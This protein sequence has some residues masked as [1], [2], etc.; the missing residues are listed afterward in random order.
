MYR[1]LVS[2]TARLF[3]PSVLVAIAALMAVTCLVTVRAPVVAQASIL[4]DEGDEVDRFVKENVA[5]GVP[6]GAPVTATGNGKLTYGLSGADSAYFTINAITGQLLLAAGAVLDFESGKTVY[7]LVVTAMGQTDQ[8]ASVNVTVNVEDVNEPPE[9]DVS[10][11]SLEVKENSPAGTNVGDPIEAADP[12]GDDVTYSLAGADANSFAIDAANGQVKIR[13]PLNFE[14]RN[15]YKVKVVASDLYGSGSSAGIDLTISVTDI[16]TEAPGKPGKPSVSPDP[17]QGHEALLVEWTAPENAGP[18]I[19]GYVVQYRVEGSGEKWKPVKVDTGEGEETITGLKSDAVY[20]VQ[21]RAVNDEGEGQWSE[22][23]K[24]RT[25]AAQTENSPPNF[26]ANAATALTVAEN[27]PPGTAVGTPFTASDA[28]PKDTLVYSLADADS[29]LFAIDDASGQISIGQRTVLDFE[30]PA[31]SD[32]NNVYELTVRVTDGKDESG[33]PNSEIDDSID[34]TVRVT[35]VNEP[36]DV[37]SLGSELE[38]DENSPGPLS[39][40]S[41]NDPEGHTVTWSLDA[42]SP[43]A[44]RFSLS[45][46]GTIAFKSTPDFETPLDNDRDNDY[47]IT[48]IATDDGLPSASSRMALSIRVVE[49]RRAGNGCVVHAGPAG[50]CSTEGRTL[51]HGWRCG[52]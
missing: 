40:L 2:A 47:E 36:P 35:N 1:P 15:S 33:N 21:V 42:A 9:F 32:G 17:A 11:V 38:A 52:R 19:T 16:D 14:A 12:E 28:D 37:S 25:Y 34:V 10:D 48:V 23:G 7:R 41:V 13:Q 39:P 49:R 8:T 30:S 4:F 18:P 27:T 3:T 31:D 45:R 22:S 29:G 20:E 43:D 26:A 6:V 5:A 24:G 46:N 44:G 51:G 50:G